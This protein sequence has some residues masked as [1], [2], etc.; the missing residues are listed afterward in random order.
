M[1]DKYT[2]E[3]RFGIHAKTGFDVSQRQ[4]NQPKPKC[5]KLWLDNKVISEGLFFV[6]GKKKRELL[7][8]GIKRER[9][10]VTY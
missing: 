2:P 6:L 5:G 8:Q 3:Q 9:I 7:M 10:K 1:E 4:T